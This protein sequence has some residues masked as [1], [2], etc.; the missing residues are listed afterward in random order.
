METINVKIDLCVVTHGAVNEHPYVN[1]S[2]NG[3]PQFSDFCSE[4][5]E[6]E[7]DI[8]L[9]EDQ[10]HTLTIEYNNKDAIND[11]VLDSSGMPELDKRIE[12]DKIA[13]DE[14]ELDFFQ[15][16]DKETLVYESTDPNGVSATGFD[17]TK[18][19]WNGRTT[20]KFETP[21]YIWLLEN[22]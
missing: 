5:Q 11:V 8:E 3:Y 18:L 16:L 15:L 12:I 21:V 7:F 1:I 9:E 19:S 10:A 13:F 20:L 2:V 4:S 17:A 14:I 6:I 22:L